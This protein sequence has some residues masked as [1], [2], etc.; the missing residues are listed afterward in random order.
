MPTIALMN[1]HAFAGGLFLALHHDYRF[2]NPSKGF[3]CL[4]EVHFGAMLPSPMAGIVKAKVSNAATVRS[5]ITEGKR[6]NAQEALAQGITDGTGGLDEVLKFIQDRSLTKLGQ[7]NVYGAL[8]EDTYREA[9]HLLDSHESND[10]WRAGLEDSKAIMAEERA[11]RV[12]AW[13]A[14][15]GKPKI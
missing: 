3:L 5:L 9:L 4:N 2:Q 6:F 8:K 7:M 1:G 12:E 13:G 10:R 14:S 15:N 11:R